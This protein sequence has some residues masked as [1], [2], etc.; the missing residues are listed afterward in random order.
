MT[1]TI[2]G[3][4]TSQGVPVI[5]CECH[6][7]NSKDSKDKRLRSSIHIQY[8]NNSIVVDTGPDF[9]QQMIDSKIKKLDAVIFTHE[10]KDHV[11]GLDDVRAF[12]FIQKK[13]IE[14][15]CS[16]NVFKALKREFHYIFDPKFKYPGVPS[17]NRNKISK[18]NTFKINEVS[19][20]PIEV[21]HYKLP[22]LGFRIDNFAYVTDAKTIENKE[23]NKLKNLDLLVINALRIREHLS[24]LNLDEALELIKE[25]NPKKAILT[26]LSHFMGKHQEIKKLIPKNVD[27]AFDGMKFNL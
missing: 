24:H 16:E 4:G 6:V 17:I 8:N 1:I 22:V 7:C 13:P 18:E 23:K 9:R 25:L 2:T 21:M 26:H 11:A 19:I 20:T 15:Y 3:S 14:I 27:V 12:N 5:G 10:H